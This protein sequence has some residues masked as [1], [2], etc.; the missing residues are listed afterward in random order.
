MRPH[1]SK[2]QYCPP[3]LAEP[4]IGLRIAGSSEA[5]PL[6]R[7][8]TAPASLAETE[9]TPAGLRNGPALR[10]KPLEGRLSCTE[11]NFRA[12]R[13]RTVVSR[14]R[15]AGRS[16]TFF[17]RAQFQDVAQGSPL[18][19]SFVARRGSPTDPSTEEPCHPPC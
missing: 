7:R 4:G 18:G 15:I 1:P 9:R 12:P 11:N 8:Q 6:R 14:R 19:L 2:V 10:S 16:C 13:F 3:L 5:G 17:L